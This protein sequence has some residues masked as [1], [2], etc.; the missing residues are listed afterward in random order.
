MMNK[1]VD[2]VVDGKILIG[3]EIPVCH[4]AVTCDTR[5]G[6]SYELGNNYHSL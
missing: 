5:M 1:H 3:E 2:R 4:I 6:N